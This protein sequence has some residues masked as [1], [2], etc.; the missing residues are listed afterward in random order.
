MSLRLSMD[1]AGGA[2]KKAPGLVLGA[3]MTRTLNP[4]QGDEQKEERWATT[5]DQS[6]EEEQVRYVWKQERENGEPH[7]CGSKNGEEN[8]IGEGLPDAM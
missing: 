4:P 3:G 7:S 1:A 8:P 5:Q 6:E 2:Q